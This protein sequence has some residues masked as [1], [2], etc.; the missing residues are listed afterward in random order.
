MKKILVIIS[1][2]LFTT[3]VEAKSVVLMIGDGMGTN[4]IN[5][6]AKDND[7]FLEKLNPIAMVKTR[8]ADNV[9]TDSAASATAYSCG[10]KTNNYYLGTKPDG[11]KCETIAEKTVKNVK[12]VYI[13][14]SDENTGATPSAFYAHVSSR[15][16]NNGINNDRMN[17]SKDMSIQLNVPS[18]HE[19]TQNLINALEQEEN[20]YFVM[21]EGAKIDKASHQGDYNWMKEELIDFDKAV[22]EM[23]DFVS[24]HDNV[25][26]LVTADHETGGLNEECVYTKNNHTA[27]D[28]YLYSH[29]ISLVKNEVDNTEVNHLMDRVLFR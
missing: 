18:V 2:M 27:A 22:H 21:I 10:I 15:Y 8:S 1:L 26:L 20:E 14:S 24:T 23:Y 5:C 13:I 29:G 3:S 7:L 6:V 19:A 17:A 12:K 28:V 4:H 25:V 11:S 9:V 16:D